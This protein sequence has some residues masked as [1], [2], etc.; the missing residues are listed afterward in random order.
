MA[1]ARIGSKQGRRFEDAK[2]ISWKLKKWRTIGAAAALAGAAAC[3]PTYYGE[4]GSYWG[5]RGWSGERGEWGERGERG[6]RG[7]RG[8]RGERGEGGERSP[9]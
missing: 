8:E 4:R 9:G 2:M 7:K 6:E 5:E 1:K 3:A